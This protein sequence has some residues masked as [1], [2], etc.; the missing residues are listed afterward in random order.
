[1]PSQCMR[2][3]GTAQMFIGWKGKGQG[4]DFS[5]F[6]IKIG[7]LTVIGFIEEGAITD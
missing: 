4:Y 1:M 7:L 2:G 5:R 3:L 6:C